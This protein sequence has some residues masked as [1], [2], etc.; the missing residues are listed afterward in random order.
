M[1]DFLVERVAAIEVLT[2]FAEH[3]VGDCATITAGEAT[4]RDIPTLDVEPVNPRSRAVFVIAEQWL[5]VT[6]GQVGGRWELD[7][8][9]AD[10]AFAQDLIGAAFQGRVTERF[11]L[12]RSRVTAVLRDGRVVRE[13][14]HDGCLS[15]FPLPGWTRW[16]RLTAYAGYRDPF[17]RE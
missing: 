14:G 17:D 3:E 7:Y 9:A 16:G 1:D 10:R 2:R 12:G 13:T 5:I 6:L 15:L 8:G 4:G 11:A